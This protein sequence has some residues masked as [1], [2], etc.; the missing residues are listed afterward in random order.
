MNKN[1]IMIK[2]K[3]EKEVSDIIKMLGTP[4]EIEDLLR[5]LNINIEHYKGLLPRFI[6]NGYPLFIGDP[7]KRS[8]DI[9]FQIETS[10]LTLSPPDEWSSILRA[11]SQTF[12]IHDIFTKEYIE[13]SGILRNA[14]IDYLLK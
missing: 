9:F 14:K 2:E 10:W 1:K 12:N 6:N 11:Y 3:L 8:S 7:F 5:I 4:K 13:T